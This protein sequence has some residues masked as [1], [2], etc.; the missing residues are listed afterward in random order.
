MRAAFTALLLAVA[1]VALAACGGNGER[2]AASSQGGSIDVALVDA[3]NT[4]DLA[5]LTPSLFTAKSH[6]KVNYTILDEGT[7]REVTTS[8]VTAGGRQFDVGL[9]GPYEAPEFGKD[10]HLTDLPR[11]APSDAAYRLDDIIPTVRNALS[12]RGKLY[13][14]PF[15]GES[16]FL[17]YR[18]DLL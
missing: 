8:D 12:Y 7:L 9:I 15:Y 2:A 3:P 10:G 6:I 1:I 11:L 16:S 13:A 4:K 17:I 18:K 14:A 5:R